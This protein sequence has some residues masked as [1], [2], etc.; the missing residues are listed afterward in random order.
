MVCDFQGIS[1]GCAPWLGIF[2]FGSAIET[3]TSE[4]GKAN[5]RG[6]ELLGAMVMRVASFLPFHTTYWLHGHDFMEAELNRAGVESGPD[7]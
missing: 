6:D 2:F 5:A 3:R 4:G 7:I 1:R